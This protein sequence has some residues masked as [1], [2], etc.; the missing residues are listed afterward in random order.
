MIQHRFNLNDR[1]KFKPTI[2]TLEFLLRN[3]EDF[4]YNAME[5]A[6]SLHQVKLFEK[7]AE[8]YVMP[9]ANDEGYISFA[10]WEFMGKF[11]SIMTPGTNPQDYF[12]DFYLEI[13]EVQ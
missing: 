2:L 4:W 3:H 8:E 13:P 11:G 12:L 9:R 10:V 5:N 7:F 1:I 6:K